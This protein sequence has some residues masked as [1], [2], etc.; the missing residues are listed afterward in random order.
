MSDYE[1]IKHFPVT[2]DA[3][4]SKIK[5][6]KRATLS[7]LVALLALSLSAY[8]FYHGYFHNSV[9]ASQDNTAAISALQQ[10][11]Q[12]LQTDLQQT[13]QTVA[14]MQTA[15]QSMLAL[16]QSTHEPQMTLHRLNFE[17][18][19]S[20]VQ[21]AYS[22]LG[23]NQDPARISAQLN[24]AASALQLAG[25][26]ALGL[27][28]QVQSLNTVVASLPQSDPN[29]ASQQLD[30][31]QQAFSS[32]EFVPAIT[33]NSA[34]QVAANVQTQ[35]QL[36]GWRSGLQHSW[37]QLKSFL[38]IRSS[39]QIGP[40]LVAES[41]R[42]DALRTLELSIAE[43]KW[44][45]ITGNQRYTNDLD[46]LQAQV[47]SYTVNNDAQQAWLKQLQAL[48]AISVV[49]PTDKMQQI[50]QGFSQILSQFDRDLTH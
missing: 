40:N 41:A 8:S 38:I 13:Q 44:D 28:K 37:Q 50:D 23:Q 10:N 39:N 9:Q 20:S 46:Q 32:L 31:L 36:S 45:A 42:F 21:L 18:A 12:A 25:P 4:Q 27:L 47:Q 15:Q 1:P 34:D 17:A 22:L 26:S 29:A 7:L 30:Q 3:S 11:N 43:A 6:R 14:A 49:Y 2:I 24:M 35:T 5:G 16:L 33:P 48:R 19:R